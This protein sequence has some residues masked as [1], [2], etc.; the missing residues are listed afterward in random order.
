MFNLKEK[1][2]GRTKKVEEVVEEVVE[3]V[4]SNVTENLDVDPN[5]PRNVKPAETGFSLNDE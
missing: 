3:V 5:D 1:L 2:M 4:D